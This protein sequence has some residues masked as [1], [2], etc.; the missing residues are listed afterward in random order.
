MRTVSLTF[1][2]VGVAA[3]VSVSQD[4]PQGRAAMD[5][6]AL[7]LRARIEAARR[8]PL[9]YKPLKIMLAPG[10]TLGMVSWIAADP[11]TRA[12]WVLQRGS[13]C[14]PILE[15][16]PDGTVLRAF[17][18]GAFK[19]PHSIRVD[20]H[21]FVWTV[22]AGSS[23]VIEW[24]RDG[25]RLLTIDVSGGRRT[26]GSEFAG[27]TDIGFAPDGRLVVSD[28]YG[29]A[30]VVEFTRQGSLIRQWGSPG[31][32]E[33]Q[34]KLPHSVVVDE[35][36]VIYVADRENGRIEEFDGGGKFLREI[37][38]LGRTYALA[39]GPAG[40]IWASMQPTDE[41]V[42]SAGWLVQFD[43]HT[44]KM[45]GYVPLAE[46]GGLHTIAL[47][48]EGEPLTDLGNGVIWFRRS[49]AGGQPAR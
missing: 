42:G 48:R 45:L 44:G 39:L 14:D 2:L 30:R 29:N 47:D 7:A 49:G 32:G 33:G 46:R 4:Q 6:R 9:E 34:F 17:G 20:A 5:A 3:L 13:G 43:R 23:Q 8:L 19:V 31:D 16:A 22:D 37:A 11:E 21:G 36:G 41:P 28:G 18:A 35:R 40:T 24:S 15:V 12:I 10:K 38:G 1:I 26:P 25:R 27:A